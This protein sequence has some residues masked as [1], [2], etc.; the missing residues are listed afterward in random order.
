MCIERSLGPPGLRLYAD[1]VDPGVQQSFG[2]Q[3][4][5]KF[6]LVRRQGDIIVGPVIG[7]VG[8]IGTTGI[9]TE[10][11]VFAPVQVFRS[12]KEKMLKKGKNYL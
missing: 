3:V 4:K 12:F 8:V 11:V 5:A 6:Q 2:F 1:L 7:R 10:F 9:R